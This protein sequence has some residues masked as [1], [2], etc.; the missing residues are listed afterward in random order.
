MACKHSLHS[1]SNLAFCKLSLG[2]V[3]LLLLVAAADG[4]DHLAASQQSAHD[5]SCLGGEELDISA[6]IATFQGNSLK[7]HCPS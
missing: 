3:Y 2:Y 4:F 5:I 6:A 1:K 7:L